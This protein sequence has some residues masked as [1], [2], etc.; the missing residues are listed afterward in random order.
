MT[1][2]PPPTTSRDVVGAAGTASADGHGRG[3]VVAGVA[4]RHRVLEHVPG[5]H[6]AAVH[7]GDRVAQHDERLLDLGGEGEHLREH[8]SLWPAEK[9]MSAS[10]TPL[11]EHVLDRDH[12]DVDAAE[13]VEVVRVLLGECGPSP[14]IVPL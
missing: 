4:R 14:E 7:V 11:R 8:P 12:V 10:V 13:L 5:A 2:A 6:R 3:V 9:P 1:D